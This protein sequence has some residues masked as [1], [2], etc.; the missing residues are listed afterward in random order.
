VLKIAREGVGWGAQKQFRLLRNYWGD[1][2]AV[3]PSITL[4]WNA[5]TRDFPRL[6]R[7]KNGGTTI[8]S[9]VG[10]WHFDTE[11]VTGK[12]LAMSD[13]AIFV[14]KYTQRLAEKHFGDKVPKRQIVIP[15]SVPQSLAIY[16]MADP[17]YLLVRAGGLGWPIWKR[18]MLS[19]SL[20]VTALWKVWPAL[21]ERHPGLGL[22]IIGNADRKLKERYHGDGI[23]YIEYISDEA[24]LHALGGKAAA[25]VHL[26]VG[27]HSPNTVCEILGE[28]RPAIV[29]DRG[30]ARELAGRAGLPVAMRE[31]GTP[32]DGV[33]DGTEVWWPLDG[34]TYA[35][36]SLS[37]LEAV[38]AVLEDPAHWRKQARKRAGE[39]KP[40]ATAAKY[41]EFMESCAK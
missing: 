35:P 34:K 38:D 6:E 25:L 3:R 17:P 28:S 1:F 19:R 27:D 22:K 4:Y 29:P 8:V 26:V 16:P 41:L 31:K 9:R 30:G 18:H 33:T 36:S 2:D 14:S 24:E 10:G 7:R 32:V 11:E 37:L 21:R 13:G 40:K 12:V 5:F 23:E 39:L 20:S 15:N